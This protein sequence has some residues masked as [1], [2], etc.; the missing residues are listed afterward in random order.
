MLLLLASIF[1]LQ[2]SRESGKKFSEVTLTTWNGPWTKID[3][4]FP[5][6]EV[7]K[8]FLEEKLGRKKF[9]AVFDSVSSSFVSLFFRA[10]VV[11][12]EIKDRVQ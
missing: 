6:F 9:M 4:N 8:F 5:K 10:K 12:T 11:K 1:L 7:G 2:S 3:L